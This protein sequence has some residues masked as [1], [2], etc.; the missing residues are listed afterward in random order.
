MS[1]QYMR[2]LEHVFNDIKNTL[3]YYTNK[4]IS[5]K[6]I[7]VRCLM[8]SQKGEM[9]RITLNDDNLYIE[10]L[11]SKSDILIMTNEMLIELNPRNIVT[12]LT[13]GENRYELVWS[14]KWC[15]RQA[16]II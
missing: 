7:K 16:D 1:T 11:K 3:Y 9:Y 15:N 2:S 5:S 8:K 4:Y 10:N 14:H 13:G 6:P 12:K